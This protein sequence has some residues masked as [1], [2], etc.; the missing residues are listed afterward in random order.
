MNEDKVVLLVGFGPSNATINFPLK[1]C[2]LVVLF[3]PDKQIF[4]DH[5]HLFFRNSNL[6]T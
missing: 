5:F 2:S 3:K 1:V 6:S 4:T